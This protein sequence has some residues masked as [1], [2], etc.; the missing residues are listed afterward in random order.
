MSIKLF[1]QG[2]PGRG[3][4]NEDVSK[5]S[6]LTRFT[7]TSGARLPMKIVRASRFSS[8]SSDGA[9]FSF[10]LTSLFGVSF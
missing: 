4:I 2:L 1:L 7:A 9:Y 10:F 8:V 5:I 3:V 6:S